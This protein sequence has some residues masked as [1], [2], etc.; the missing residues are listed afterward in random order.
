MGPFIGFMVGFFDSISNIIYVSLFNRAF[1]VL[2]NFCF[3]IE[4]KPTEEPYMWF[5]VYVGI[6]ILQILIGK[7][8]FSLFTVMGIIVLAIP[9]IF[10]LGTTNLQNYHDNVV[11]PERNARHALFPL[12]SK[13]FLQLLPISGLLYFGIDMLCLVCEDTKNAAVVVPR[14]LM[15]VYVVIFSLAVALI[16]AVASQYP[17]VTYAPYNPLPMTF[18]FMHMFDTVF[19]TASITVL[20]SEIMEVYALTYA[21]GRQ[22]C[23]LSRSSL[24]PPMFS[25]TTSSNVPYMSLILGSTLG[26]LNLVVLYYI[27]KEKFALRTSL[28]YYVAQLCSI[29]VYVISMLSFLVFRYKYSVL[30]RHFHIRWAGVP[31]ALLGIGIFGI[32]WIMLAAFVDADHYFIVKAYAVLFAMGT[33]FY[34]LYARSRQSFSQEEQSILF[35][36]YVIKANSRH[37]TV[38]RWLEKKWNRHVLR[39]VSHASS[40]LRSS[41]RKSNQKTKSKVTPAENTSDANAVKVFSDSKSK[42]SSDEIARGSLMSFDA[43]RTSEIELHQQKAEGGVPVMVAPLSQIPGSPP[44]TQSPPGGGSGGYLPV[45]KEEDELDQMMEQNLRLKATSSK[46][47]VKTM[48][49]ALM[50]AEFGDENRS[51]SRG[52]NYA[53]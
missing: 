10:I 38:W 24:L 29:T 34:F 40:A 21:F 18:G 25:W 41:I 28:M 33:T 17:G 12:G 46:N 53:V 6:V 13:G 19:Q 51:H 8:S 15:T 27:D 47:D 52:S 11:V 44:D 7:Y 42:G 50:G 37:R 16:F 43:S 14:V 32:V 20:P 5:L 30:E 3:F 23:A 45:T 9:L 48:E 22:M 4:Y 26:M 2:F 31:V 49:Q 36:V 1:V 39:N 35:A